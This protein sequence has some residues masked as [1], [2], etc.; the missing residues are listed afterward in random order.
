MCPFT[1]VG[2]PGWRGD[3]WFADRIEVF[4]NYTL[5]S[6]QNQSNK[7]FVLWITFRPEE[8]S[9][10]LMSRLEQYLKMA[11]MQYVMTFNGLM[12]HDDKYTKDINSRVKN[13]GRLVRA[14]WR[15]GNWKDLGKTILTSLDD[16]NSTLEFRLGASLDVLRPYFGDADHVLLT[17]IDS[18]DMFR[19]DAVQLIQNAA[20]T[21][22][23]EAISFSAGY[24]HNTTTGEVAEYDPATNPPFHTLIFPGQVFF[25]HHAH[26]AHYGW[27]KSHEDIP[28]I[29]N[30]LRY[31]FRAF[32]VTT[33]SP[34]N[35]I[36]TLYRHPYKGKD[37]LDA[38]E[39]REILYSFGIC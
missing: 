18:D 26:L 37:I 6:L 3:A 39:R 16:K 10:P 30:T 34:K 4:K 29:F 25:N 9:N 13:W 12:Y 17:R 15:N 36:S 7:N 19:H 28:H 2:V 31:E 22:M 21:G 1:G 23:Y 14:C 27:F 33:H 11:D 24:I 38:E 32:C 20:F 8:A 35:H 5:K